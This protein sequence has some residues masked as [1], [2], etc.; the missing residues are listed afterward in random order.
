MNLLIN[1]FEALAILGVSLLAAMVVVTVHEF[2]HAFTSWRLGDK[3][4]RFNRRL[5]LSPISHTDIVGAL[6]F[7]QTGFGWGNPVETSPKHYKNKKKG[8]ILV[9]VSGPLASLALAVA[10]GLVLRVIEVMTVAGAFPIVGF[11]A[12]LLENFVRAVYFMSFNFAVISLI[13]MHPFDGFMVWGKV[14][15]PKSQFTIFQ[16]QGLILTIFLLVVLIAPSVIEM[17]IGFLRQIIVGLPASGIADL[18][19]KFIL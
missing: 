8:T 4:P 7:M 6:F 9:G 19:M 1:I 15:S 5:T 14:I 10:G 11:P 3:L 18:V 12:A 13:P 2:A 17:P 16:H